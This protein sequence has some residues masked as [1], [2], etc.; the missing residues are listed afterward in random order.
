MLQAYSTDV[1][2]SV[3]RLKDR[4]E[5]TAAT[6]ETNPPVDE[7][8]RTI[9]TDGPSICKQWMPHDSFCDR[10]ELERKQSIQNSLT[11]PESVR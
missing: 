7:L 5:D 4:P 1:L 10:I 11:L 9:S 8:Y 3:K 2:L 6:K